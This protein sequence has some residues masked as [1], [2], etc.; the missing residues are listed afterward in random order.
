MAVSSGSEALTILA[1]QRDRERP[2]VLICD[3][4]IASQSSQSSLL[5]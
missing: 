4:A 1:D 5:L 3:I 2:D